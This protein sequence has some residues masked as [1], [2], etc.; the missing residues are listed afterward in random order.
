MFFF[1][2][3]SDFIENGRK[4]NCS[5]KSTLKQSKSSTNEKESSNRF[6]SSTFEYESSDGFMYQQITDS[7]NLDKG[8]FQ[9]TENNSLNETTLVKDDRDKNNHSKHEKAYPPVQS[10]HVE[11]HFNITNVFEDCNSE[12]NSGHHYMV[13]DDAKALESN[14]NSEIVYLDNNQ[15]KG[16][17]N[18]ENT[19][20]SDKKTNGKSINA[21]VYVIFT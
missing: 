12:K 16:T 17:L 5:K 18:Q 7:S 1:S 15:T 14:S 8:N 11:L 13:Y 4:L 21:P 9:M 6:K 19:K 3:F 2:R 10:D 20:I